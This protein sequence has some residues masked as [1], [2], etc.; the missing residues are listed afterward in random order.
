[1]AK[2]K[3][4]QEEEEPKGLNYHPQDE[5]DEITGLNTNLETEVP[6]YAALNW[7]D[8]NNEGVNIPPPRARRDPRKD[9]DPIEGEDLGLQEDDF[10]LS[11]KVTPE[12]LEAHNEINQ[13][14]RLGSNMRDPKDFAGIFTRGAS[15]N[16][17]PKVDTVYGIENNYV[18]QGEVAARQLLRNC[19]SRDN[20]EK[21]NALHIL[22]S[23]GL[24]DEVINE[25]K[26]NRNAHDDDD[27]VQMVGEQL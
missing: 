24:D 22:R 4:K 20:Q 27:L 14:G 16:E 1:M 2:K 9:K 18:T 10:L 11:R 19:H 25:I 3:T 26:S 15:T 5:L 8:T 7:A 17:A 21:S 13:E 6:E 12:D 23:M